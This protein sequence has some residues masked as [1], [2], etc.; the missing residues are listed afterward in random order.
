VNGDGGFQLNIHELETVRRLKLPIKFFIL[1][2][3]GYA[4]I[5]ATQRNF[6]EGRFVGSEPGSRLTLP[7]ITRVAEAYGI[8][9]M[10]IDGQADIRRRVRAALDAP[11]PL[12]CAVRV[13]P[14]QLT[15][16]RVKSSVRADGSME[17]K[18]MEDLWPFLDRD[19]FQANLLAAPA[20]AE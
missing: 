11:G 5:I 1:C 13:S 15:I 9:T 16:P 3:G 12:V 19:E 20:T 14:D 8:A 2:N 4:S 18:P 17:S 6:F 7:D 10:R